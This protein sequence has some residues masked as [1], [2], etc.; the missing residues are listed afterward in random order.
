MANRKRKKKTGTGR[1]NAGKT[2]LE[3]KRLA[4][5]RDVGKSLHW[6]LKWSVQSSI[7]EGRRGKHPWTGR[8]K[9]EKWDG[10]FDGL[11]TGLH[12]A[13]T[14]VGC[15]RIDQ[16]SR[17]YKREYEKEVALWMSLQTQLKNEL[18]LAYARVWK[19][20]EALEALDS[21]P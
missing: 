16:D 11:L 21:A 17:K 10:Y 20:R 5:L 15:V 7:K 6:Y 12:I 1:K 13:M 2:P 14:G 8:I 3:K 9:S 19:I 18:D 4:F